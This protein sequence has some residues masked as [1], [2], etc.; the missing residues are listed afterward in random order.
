MFCLLSFTPLNA[1][2]ISRYDRFLDRKTDRILIN[3]LF[4]LGSVMKF[5]AN[6]GSVP[7]IMS[8]NWKCSNSKFG[9]YKMLCGEASG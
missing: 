6:I 4:H 9:K 2:A 7:R 3:T 1:T 5:Y 8:H